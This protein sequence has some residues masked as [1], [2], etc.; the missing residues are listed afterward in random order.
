MTAGFGLQLN[1]KRVLLYVVVSLIFL[2]GLWYM[3]PFRVYRAFDHIEQ[4]AKKRITA[5]ELQAWATNLLAH[6]LTN[7][8]PSVSELGTN[9][10]K[11]LRSL[12]RHPPYIQVN[13]AT[14][15]YPAYVYLMW[16]GGLIGH[17]G[18]EIGPTNYVSYRSH[19]RTW[20][21]GVYFWSDDPPK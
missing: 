8:N 13:E 3:L 5:N 18:F 16:G 4:R 20:Q 21:P 9:F 19:A 17:C 11:Q 14:T 12:Y 6:P 15:N 7:L 2:T 1:M 10:P